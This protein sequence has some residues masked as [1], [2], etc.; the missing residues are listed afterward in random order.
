[1]MTGVAP[2]TSVMLSTDTDQTPLRNTLEGK[3]TI[4]AALGGTSG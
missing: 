1:M 4:R 2:L 3:V